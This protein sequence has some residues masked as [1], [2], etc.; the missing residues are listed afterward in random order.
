MSV[1]TFPCS[2]CGAELEFKP[3]TRHLTCPYCRADVEIP[4]RE[5]DEVR[6]VE[7]DEVLRQLGDKQETDEV[8]TVRCDSCRAEVPMA[9]NVTSQSCPFCGSNI[10]AT[11]QSQRHV[12]PKAVLPFAVNRDRAR[13]L[14]RGWLAGRWFAPGKLKQFAAIDDARGT[15]GT[16]LQGIYL[17][18]WTYDCRSTTGYDG[19]RGDDY[20]VQVPYTAMVNGKPVTRMRQE[21]RTR[22]TPVSG[23]VE[24]SFDDVLV[25][26]SS[27]LPREQ[28]D[29]VGTWDLKELAPYSD[30][31][32]AGFTAESYT[33]DLPTG[34]GVARQIME[35]EIRATVAR[36]IGGDHQRITRMQPSFRNITFKHIL[37]PVWVAAYRYNNRVYRFLINARTGQIAGQRPYSAW[38]IAA[39]VIAGAFVVLAVILITSR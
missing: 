32:L 20:F 33:V 2:A 30:Q 13:E 37:L 18:Y 10:V 9:A 16:G 12:K 24:N 17:P 34:F 36:D 28:L 23:S 5:E 27:S 29:E 26:A 31:Y 15:K 4:R 25:P 7:Y 8:I 35:G 3:G 22:W 11:G 38:K 21:V 19:Q 39:L 6:E 14:F 1:A